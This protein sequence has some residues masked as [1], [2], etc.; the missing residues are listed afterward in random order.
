MSIG[1]IPKVAQ[2]ANEPPNG[3][4]GIGVFIGPGEDANGDG[5][6]KTNRLWFAL[7]PGASASRSIKVS[8]TSLITQTI[9][10]GTIAGARVNGGGLEQQPDRE[11]QIGRAH[12]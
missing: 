3:K 2:G 1:I 7:P 4:L 6:E 8:S 9:T 10:L 11:D 5:L 12:V